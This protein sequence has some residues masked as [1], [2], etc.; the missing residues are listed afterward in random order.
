MLKVL[1]ADDNRDAAESLAMVLEIEPPQVL[2]AHT[3]EQALQIAQA[4]RCRM[5]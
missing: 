4:E 5:P 2:V 3:G 1:V